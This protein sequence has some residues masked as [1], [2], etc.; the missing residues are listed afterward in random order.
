MIRCIKCGRVA[1]HA[2][3]LLERDVDG[4][5]IAEHVPAL[6]GLHYEEEVRVQYTLPPDPFTSDPEVAMW[7]RITPLYLERVHGIL[8]MPVYYRI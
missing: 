2:Q 3:T 6:C 7:R 5:I 4:N 8:G 1:V